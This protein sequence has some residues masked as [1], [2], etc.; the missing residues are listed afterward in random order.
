MQWVDD[1]YFLYG[2]F[3]SLSRVQREFVLKVSSFS[4]SSHN[5]FVGLFQELFWVRQLSLCRLGDRRYCI[6][7]G[8]ATLLSVS[9]YARLTRDMLNRPGAKKATEGLF[10]LKTHAATV[11]AHRAL[12]FSSVLSSPRVVGRL[13]SLRWALTATRP[14]MTTNKEAK[15][16]SSKSASHIFVLFNL[17]LT[18]L[19]RC[20][21]I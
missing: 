7:F 13:L 2:N 18:G 3:L 11:A 9:L 17:I 1:F 6:V 12:R 16:V 20:G 15:T 19:I 8:G 21:V 10:F 4:I 5:I 14:R